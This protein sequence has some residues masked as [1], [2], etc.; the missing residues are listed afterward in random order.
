MYC[1]L[2]KENKNFPSYIRKFRR[3]RVQSHIW[4]TVCFYMVKYLR[5]SSY[6]K[7][8]FLIYDFALLYV[9]EENFPFILSVYSVH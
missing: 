9:Y 8:P 7:K 6:I 4:L 1:T 2:I 5:N 3:E